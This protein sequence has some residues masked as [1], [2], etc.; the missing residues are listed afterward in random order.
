[1]LFNLSHRRDALFNLNHRRNVLFN[2]NLGRFA[3]GMGHLT[4]KDSVSVHQE[5]YRHRPE[6]LL[7]IEYRLVW[8]CK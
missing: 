6:V 7:T 3:G 8:M 5:P 2:L 4:H 1:M